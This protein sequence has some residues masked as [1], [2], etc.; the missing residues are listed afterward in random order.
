MRSF[1]THYQG[2]LLRGKTVALPADV[3]GFVLRQDNLKIGGK[4]Q[5]QNYA[6]V[7]GT[8]K[9]MTYWNH[10]TPPSERDYVPQAMRWFEVAR[11]VHAPLPLEA[12]KKS[13]DTTP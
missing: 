2:R 10:D 8:F 1:H 13:E 11:K 6:T 9:E 12:E 4:Q 5:A 7:T 3:A